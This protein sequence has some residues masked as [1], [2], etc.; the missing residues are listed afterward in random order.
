MHLYVVSSRVLKS[1]SPQF[2]SPLTSTEVGIQMSPPMILHPKRKFSRSWHHRWPLLLSGQH[3]WKRCTTMAR[4][5]SS[6]LVPSVH[7]PCLPSKFSRT[8]QRLSPIPTIQR[9]EGLLHS[10]VHSQFMLCL[11]VF[12]T[13][14]KPM[15][16]CLQ[17]PS[18]RV[19]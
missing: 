1:T 5:C 17:M 13:G 11:G 12:Q 7:W 6:K 15:M 3:K 8:S 2:Q 19:Q 9:W 10:T 18:M 14:Q 16:A 4:A